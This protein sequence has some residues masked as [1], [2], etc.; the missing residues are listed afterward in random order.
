[1][2]RSLLEVYSGLIVGATIDSLTSAGDD[3]Q[4]LNT[5]GMKKQMKPTQCRF[6]EPDSHT[7]IAEGATMSHFVLQGELSHES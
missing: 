2:K 7:P 3:S 6:A 1:M 5:R 4:D